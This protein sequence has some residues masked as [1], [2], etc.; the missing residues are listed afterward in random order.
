MKLVALLSLALVEMS[1]ASAADDSWIQ[2]QALDWSL[3][4]QAIM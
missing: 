4:S 1:V 2:V 3:Q